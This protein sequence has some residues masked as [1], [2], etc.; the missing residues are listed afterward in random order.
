MGY[1]TRKLYM[2]FF[3][4]IRIYNKWKCY[5][6]QHH[7]AK[8]WPLGMSSHKKYERKKRGD[9]IL[10]RNRKKRRKKKLLSKTTSSFIATFWQF[11]DEN[12]F[13]KCLEGHD[14]CYD[15]FQNFKKDINLHWIILYKLNKNLGKSN[16][17][18]IRQVL[19]GKLLKI[20]IEDD[21]VHISWRCEWND[22]KNPQFNFSGQNP[23]S[24]RNFFINK[25]NF[26]IEFG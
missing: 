18:K 22:R 2:I 1:G 25:D 5:H 15:R 6:H 19:S 9:T 20:P 10:H 17:F 13:S 16:L 3:F 14:F 23:S 7:C 4:Q 21:L 26:S 11:L 12:F 8:M 24:E